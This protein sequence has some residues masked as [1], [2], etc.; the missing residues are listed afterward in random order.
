[1]HFFLTNQIIPIPSASKYHHGRPR[2]FGDVTHMLPLFCFFRPVRG[3]KKWDYAMIGGARK[4][5]HLVW[6]EANKNVNYQAS[7][8][9]YQFSLHGALHQVLLQCQT[10]LNAN[11]NSVPDNLP[12]Y[13]DSQ[14]AY[15]MSK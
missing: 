5:S 4:S 9:C 13:F 2:L 7:S 8:R 12:V 14:N 10:L 11:S 6:T 15:A 1:M 3:K